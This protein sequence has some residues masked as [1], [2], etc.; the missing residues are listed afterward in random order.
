[1]PG[2]AEG[3]SSEVDLELCSGL[4]VCDTHRRAPVRTADAEDLEGITVQGALRHDDPTALQ[5]LMGLFD[6]E[7][8]LDEPGL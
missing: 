1:L 4:A 6:R 8:V 3:H 5:E 2:R 7:L